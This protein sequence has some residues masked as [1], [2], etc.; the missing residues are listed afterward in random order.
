MCAAE[1]LSVRMNERNC[2][3][4][5]AKYIKTHTTV[6]EKEEGDKTGKT[7][8]QPSSK[9]IFSLQEGRR[10]ATNVRGSELLQPGDE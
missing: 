1:L 7:F 2:H 3:E 8:W 4:Q 5:A 6:A 9:T 10:G